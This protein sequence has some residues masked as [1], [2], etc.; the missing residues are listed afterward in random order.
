MKKKLLL[1]SS[2]LLGLIFTFLFLHKNQDNN[3]EMLTNGEIVKI[4][5]DNLSNSPFK[6]SLK[7]TK[8]Q[9]KEAGLPPNKFAEEEYELTMNP[10]TGRPTFENL[11]PIRD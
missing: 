10:I 3:S 6:Q 4:H 8:E 5:S 11:K 9:R 2:I 1:V 7:L